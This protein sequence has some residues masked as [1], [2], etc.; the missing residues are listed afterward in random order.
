MGGFY[1]WD[2]P[3][4]DPLLCEVAM[5]FE[6]RKPICTDCKWFVAGQCHT[7]G[8]MLMTAAYIKARLRGN[9]VSCKY[10]E[11]EKR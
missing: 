11:K 9:S 8:N 10:Y 1:S 4:F 5:A 7:P 6:V 3:G 2:V